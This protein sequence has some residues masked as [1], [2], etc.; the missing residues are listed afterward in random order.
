VDSNSLLTTTTTQRRTLILTRS[1][2]MLERVPGTSA[3]EF[4]HRLA[5]LLLLL[6]LLRRRRRSS[7]GIRSPLV[8]WPDLSAAEV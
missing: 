8:V 3:H 7:F 4:T 2:I 6:P 5:L 1:S